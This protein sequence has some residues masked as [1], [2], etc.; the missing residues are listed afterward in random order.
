[1]K[2]LNKNKKLIYLTSSDCSCP[3]C[4]GKNIQGISRVTGYMSLDERFCDGK[5]AERSYRRDHNNKHVKNY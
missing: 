4:G 2:K 5:V 3:V 1:M